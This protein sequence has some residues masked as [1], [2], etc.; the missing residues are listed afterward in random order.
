MVLF[1]NE[2]QTQVISVDTV[3]FLTAAF[4]KKTSIAW[5]SESYHSTVKSAGLTFFFFLHF[6][7]LSNLIKI[8]HKMLH[9]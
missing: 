3:K 4:F 5:C 2:G 7:V 8:L 6:H 1:K 9:K